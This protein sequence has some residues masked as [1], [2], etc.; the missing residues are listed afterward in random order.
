MQDSVPAYK[1]QK[2][3]QIVEVKRSVHDMQVYGM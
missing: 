3:N 1:V 2:A